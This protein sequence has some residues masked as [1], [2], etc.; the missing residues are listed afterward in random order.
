MVFSEMTSVTF[1]ELW[2]TY[3]LKITDNWNKVTCKKCLKKRN[4]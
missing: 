2:D 3:G 1:A 4:K